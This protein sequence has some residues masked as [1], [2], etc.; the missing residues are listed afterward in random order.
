MK[1]LKKGSEVEVTCEKEMFKVS[2]N[3]AILQENPAKVKGKKLRVCFTTLVDKDTLSPYTETVEQCFIRPVQPEY[4]NKGFVFERGSVVDAYDHAGWWKYV[5]VKEVPN[6]KFLVYFNFIPDI[7]KFDKYQLRPNADWTGSKW[8]LSEDI[9]SPGKI[10]EMTRRIRKMEDIWVPALLIKQIEVDDIVEVF[11][12]CGWLKGEV[13]EILCGN[14]YLV[15]FKT[16]KEE[17]VYKS[18]AL[19]PSMDWQDGHW[20]HTREVDVKCILGDPEIHC[21]LVED[22]DIQFEKVLDLVRRGYRLKRQD[23]LNGSINIAV[24]EAE[25]EKNN[26]D[27]WIDATDKEKIE[28]LT[29]QAEIYKE[30]VGYLEGLLN[31][32]R[33]NEKVGE[34]NENA[35]KESVLVKKKKRA[36]EDKVARASAFSV[37]LVYGS[38]K[39]KF[40]KPRM[41]NLKKKE[42]PLPISKGCEVEAS[43]GEDGFQGSWFRA[44]LEQDP[45]KVKGEKLRVCYK[46]LLHEDGVKRCRE[47]VERCFIRPVPP[48]CLNEGVKFKEGLVV[49]AYL[50]DGW[51]NG[52]IEVSKDMFI[53]RKLV[54]VTRTIGKKENVWVQSLVVK[55]IRGG[56]KR[57]FLVKRYLG[58]SSQHLS[59]GEEEKCTAVDICKI[60]PSR[61]LNLS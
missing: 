41:E 58:P 10:V 38:M 12:S 16:V 11:V 47:Y 5:I 13:R 30:R 51:W 15:Q 9:Y 59:D 42:R 14:K 26:Y 19:R 7:A 34:L 4:L 25:V 20:I 44:I 36:R 22:V 27:P 46:T 52:V 35:S 24:A 45:E 40:L 54:E 53:T 61:P 21:D 29:K 37:G 28:F 6:D 33:E 23:W 55:E 1:K 43:P 57:E 2:W 50:N 60:R 18:S 8:Q 48:E 49:D 32:R 17:A 39:L 56:D 3:K 31:I